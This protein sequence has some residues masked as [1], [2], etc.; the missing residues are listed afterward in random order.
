MRS[1]CNARITSDMRSSWTCLCGCSSTVEGSRSMPCA[2]AANVCVGNRKHS[3]WIGDS[4]S[5]RL[6]TPAG[7][8]F[9][10]P[11]LRWKRGI[12]G[13]SRH[14]AAAGEPRCSEI[15]WLARACASHKP[16]GWRWVDVNVLTISLPVAVGGLANYACLA[17]CVRHTPCRPALSLNRRE[18]RHFLSCRATVV[19]PFF[20]QEPACKS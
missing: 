9:I 7:T 6:R 13:M 19:I 8:M 15:P 18:T 1:K 12:P 11:S 14:V 17:V 10:P 20:L 16:A 3:I 4:I 5:Q 2:T